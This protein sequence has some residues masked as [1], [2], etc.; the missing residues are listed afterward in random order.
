[1]N[2][3]GQWLLELVDL[4]H[5]VKD[6]DL[7]WQKNNLPLQSEL[8]RSQALAEQALEAELKTKTVQLEHELSLLRTQNSAQLTML[9]TRCK[10]DIQDY[11]Q[12][13]ASLDKLKIS[14]QNSFTHLPESFGFTIHHHA[15]YLMHQMWEAENL[16]EKL[17]HE[18]NLIQFMTA[19]HEDARLNLEDVR[20]AGVPE[21]TLQLIQHK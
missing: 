8:R 16:E 21:K 1:M 13:L 10:Q 19:V 3:I 12:Y 14:I 4:F 20:A 15:K 9:K 18:I 17:Q 2:G 11:K 7:Q 5:S 6:K